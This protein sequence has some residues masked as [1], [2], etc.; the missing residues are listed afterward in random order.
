MVYIQVI[1]LVC[2]YFAFYKFEQ[3]DAFSNDFV[4]H[5][6]VP[7]HRV[8]AAV[9]ST[10]VDASVPPS[11]SSEDPASGSDSSQSP[12]TDDAATDG[13]SESQDSDASLAE[14]MAAGIHIVDFESD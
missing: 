4:L 8:R 9:D 3:E 7:F 12:Q 11:A 10:S 1:V 14:E 6:R 2:V 13:A 5:H